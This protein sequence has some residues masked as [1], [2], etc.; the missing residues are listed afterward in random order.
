[1]AN[2]GTVEI[3]DDLVP[4]LVPVDGLQHY[5]G[6]PRKGN[7]AAI[8]ASLEAHGLYRPLVV[9]KS[10]GYILTGNHLFDA[11]TMGGGRRG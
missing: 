7:V 11:L 3:R 5:P 9:Q 2:L 6:N 1:M 10:T 8:R 4:L